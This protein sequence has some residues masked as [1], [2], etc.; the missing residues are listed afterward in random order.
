MG[1]VGVAEIKKSRWL[2]DYGRFIRVGGGTCLSIGRDSAS[3]L[4]LLYGSG[5]S[6]S[7]SREDE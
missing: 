4:P 5:F 2:D 7:S 1:R 3:L 6:S